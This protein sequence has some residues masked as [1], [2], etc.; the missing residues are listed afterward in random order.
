VSPHSPGVGFPICPKCGETRSPFASEAELE[1][2]R[3]SHREYCRVADIPWTALHVDIP[4]DVLI[5]GP[6]PELADGINVIEA[7]RIGAQMVL[8]MGDSEVAGFV[9][10]D[11]GG[12]HWAVL[13]DPMPG[14]SGFLPQI[15]KYWKVVCERAAERL[16]TCNCERACYKCLQHFRNQ[17]H[18]ALLDRYRTIELMSELTAQL[19]QE[20]IIPPVPA[21]PK[22]PQGKDE[23]DAEVDLLKILQDRS[24]PL[25][26]EAQFRVDL[27]GGSSTVA[28][29][30]YPDQRILIFVDG[31]SENIHGSPA[32]QKKDKLQRAK[33][34]MQGYRVLEMTAQALR[35]DTT[36][37]L[38]LNELAVYLEREDL[39]GE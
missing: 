22:P 2:F 21:K 9:D 1:K 36:V 10:T 32:Q 26:P 16:G 30:A 24:F 27:G 17:Q 8:D 34:K 35:D 33:A 25:P 29:Y 13:Y 4:S 5:V 18:H 19:K 3:E 31:M 11:E 12:S 20:H 14:G 28:D 7:L 37:A 23:S 38:F 15:C 6:F 39:V